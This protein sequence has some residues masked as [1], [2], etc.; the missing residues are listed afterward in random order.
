MVE[1]LFD[2][3]GTV[4]KGA[5]DKFAESVCMQVTVSYTMQGN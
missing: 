1:P 4:V 5:V 3:R 2:E